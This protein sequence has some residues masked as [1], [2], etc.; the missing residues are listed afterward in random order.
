MLFSLF[1]PPVVRIGERGSVDRLPRQR[2]NDN[3]FLPDVGM[4]V[5][6]RNGS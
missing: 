4:G 6:R 3:H 1:P 2:G 5:E